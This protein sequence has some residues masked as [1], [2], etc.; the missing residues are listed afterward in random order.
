MK[1]SVRTFLTLLL[2]AVFLF[3]T[4]KYLLD[5][6][7]K[8]VGNSA[9]E[10]ALQLATSPKTEIPRTT[11]ATEAPSAEPRWVV[12]PVEEEDPHIETLESLDLNALRAVNPDV[13]GWILIPDTVINYPLMQAEDNSY[14]LERTWD[15]KSNAMGS[16]FLEQLS[17]ADLTDKNTIVYGHNMND[18][19][20]FAS[21]RDY[22]EQAYYEAHPYVYIL[23]DLGVYRYEIF[24][25][26]TASIKSNTYG[27]EFPTE[28]SWLRFLEKGLE[29]SVIDTGVQPEPTDRVLTLSTCAGANR[30][31]RWVV[32]A[33]L[34][35]VLE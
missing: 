5:Q 17:S 23:T 6:R 30:S 7:D 3:S 27:V 8:A 28:T 24:S 9:Y 4:G 35:M 21:L 12:A 16:I 10:E 15:R 11:A 34:K 29:D 32:H 20:M 25:C 13:V 14:Y 1:R 22:R 19:S 2:T 18:G 31:A 26:Y 33:R